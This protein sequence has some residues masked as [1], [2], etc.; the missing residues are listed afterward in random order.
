M[1]FMKNLALRYNKDTP[2]T[3]HI[4]RA[5]IKNCLGDE[6]S[7][8]SLF[9]VNIHKMKNVTII[10]MRVIGVAARIPDKEIAEYVKLNFPTAMRDNPVPTNQL[11]IVSLSLEPSR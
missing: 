11:T 10:S 6:F 4:K 9:T 7:N 5:G 2:V 3:K 1:G 8:T